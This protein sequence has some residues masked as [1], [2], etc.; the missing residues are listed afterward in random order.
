MKY[1]RTM[2]VGSIMTRVRNEEA[3]KRC[4]SVLTIDEL[5]DINFV[6]WYGHVERMEEREWLNCCT[7]CGRTD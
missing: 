3:W 1:M 5:M 7:G 6:K 4:D 2:C